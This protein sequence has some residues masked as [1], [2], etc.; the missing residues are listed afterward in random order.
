MKTKQEGFPPK[1]VKYRDYKNFD[2]KVFKNRLQL[3]FKNIT[4]F[5]KI[6]EIFMDLLKKFDPLN[7][8]KF[9]TKG[10]IKAIMPRTRFRHRF[11]KKSDAKLK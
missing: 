4:F 1:I 5:E 10:L 3:L 8:N 7:R 6:K 2:T 9:M 11:L